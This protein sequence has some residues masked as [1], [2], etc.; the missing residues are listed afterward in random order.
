MALILGAVV[1]C[2]GA[3]LFLA[4]GS[5]LRAELLFFGA[6]VLAVLSSLLGKWWTRH[7]K[8]RSLVI[9]QRFPEAA[10]EFQ[11]AMQETNFADDDPRRAMLLDGLAQA[12]KGIGDYADAEPIAREA[13]EV[14]QAAWGERSKQAAMLLVNLGNIYLDLAR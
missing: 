5:L 10:E 3:I 9:K 1:L 14:A 4:F 7:A 12:I 8:G 6:V 2:V 13:L 11:K